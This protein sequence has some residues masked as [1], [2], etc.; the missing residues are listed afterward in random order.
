[1]NVK[2]VC[3][4]GLAAANVALV[5]KAFNAACGHYYEEESTTYA[6]ADKMGKALATPIALETITKKRYAKPDTTL[7]L[8]L[9]R[10]RFPDDFQDIKKSERKTLNVDIAGEIEGFFGNLGFVKKVECKETSS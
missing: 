10:F 1:V 5:A 8:N 9:L 2:R 3:E 6:R 7:L 4:A